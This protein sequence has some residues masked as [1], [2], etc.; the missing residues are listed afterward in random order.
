MARAVP[1]DGTDNT[2]APAIARPR[3]QRITNVLKE[4]VV[5]R[6]I[7]V[8]MCGVFILPFYW[9]LVVA[10]KSNAELSLSPPTL[11]P[12]DPQWGN[13]ADATEVFPF[14]QFL[15]NTATITFFTVLGAAISNPIVAYGFSR[16]DWPGRDKVFALVLATVFIPFPVLIIA[17]FDI[18]A[19]LG[20]INTILPLVVPMFFGSAFWIFL[21]RQF[22]MQ[23]P[24][25]LSDAAK[26]DGASE[27]RI[28]FQII[29]PQSYA[30]VSVVCI[31]AAL[32]AWNDYLGP[33]LFLQE[34][35]QYTLAIGLS[36]FQSQSTYD[37]QYNLLM[38]AS[39]LVILPVVTLFLFFQRTFVEGISMGSIK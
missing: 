35:S 13:F 9:M 31:F 28:L 22:F 21:M 25:E 4:Q 26:L 14:W 11:W 16:I 29:L 5:P 27:L 17:L 23:I 3:G 32:H 36:F 8:L 19:R 33:L 7:L 6:I 2:R 39:A 10:L 20:W 30:A 34:P 18:F 15:R 37:I 24:R 12:H 1:I 38:A